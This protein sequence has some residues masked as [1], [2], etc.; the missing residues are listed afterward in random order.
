MTDLEKL[1]NTF[2]EIGVEYNIHYDEYGVIVSIKNNFE[3]EIVF[4]KGKY[5]EKYI[6]QE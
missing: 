5:I 3:S 6:N 1:T 2:D 4:S